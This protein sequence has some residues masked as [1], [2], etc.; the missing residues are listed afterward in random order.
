VLADDGVGPRRVDD[1]EVAQDLGGVAPLQEV[2]LHHLLARLVAVAHE[3]DAVGGGGDALGRIFSPRRALMKELFPELNSPAITSRK[4]E[5][6]ASR[7][8]L[9]WRRSSASTSVPKRPSAVESGPAARARGPQLQLALS[10]QPVSP[11]QQSQRHARSSACPW[12]LAPQSR[13][14]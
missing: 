10:Q 14:E 5:E 7:A 4:K 1:V 6:S 12:R 8:W 11:P 9:K 13:G 3:V 2:R